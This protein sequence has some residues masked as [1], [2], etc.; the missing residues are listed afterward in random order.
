[1]KASGGLPMKMSSASGFRMERGKQSQ[2]AI[3][4]RWKCMVPLGLP[5]V[6]EVKA[7][8]TVWSR[9]VS[10]FSKSAGLPAMRSSSSAPAPGS[11]EP[12]KVQ[13]RRQT[14]AMAT[15]AAMSSASRSS[16]SA[17]PISALS[18]MVA[19]SWPRSSGMVA[20]T[21]P[22]ALA[23]ANQQAMNMGLLAARISTRLPGKRPK[24]SVRT[25]A[26]RLDFS[27]RSP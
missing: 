7:I 11:P 22:P 19:I 10:R 25:R 12:L 13:T 21:M 4:S 23:M 26:M 9:E 20:T 5:V 15:A 16:H 3:T 27:S 6:P 2:I 17:S 1:V 18:R 24:S 8:S 14:G